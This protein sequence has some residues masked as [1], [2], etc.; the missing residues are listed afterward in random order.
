MCRVGCAQVHSFAG[1]VQSLLLT[2]IED[3]DRLAGGAAGRHR[4][5]ASLSRRGA[6]QSAANDV[7][8]KED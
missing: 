4:N 8:G 1:W 7:Q 5:G 3:M 2:G 6:A